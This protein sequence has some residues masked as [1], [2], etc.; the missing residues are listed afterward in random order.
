MSRFISFVPT[1]PNSEI[2]SEVQQKRRTVQSYSEFRPFHDHRRINNQVDT[3]S[4]TNNESTTVEEIPD[5]VKILFS[6]DL[7]S[8]FIF[9]TTTEVDNQLEENVDIPREQKQINCFKC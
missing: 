3:P 9:Q 1:I 4:I 6:F 2:T 8:L 7:I 5:E